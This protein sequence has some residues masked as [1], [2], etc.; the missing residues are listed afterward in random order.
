ML[1]HIFRFD[2]KMHNI[3][4]RNE[5]ACECGLRQPHY[6]SGSVATPRAGILAAQII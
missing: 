6:R 4:V 5:P 1:F 2:A 3:T